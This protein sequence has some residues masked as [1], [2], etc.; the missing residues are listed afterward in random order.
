MGNHVKEMGLSAALEGID[1]LGVARFDAKSMVA[2]REKQKLEQMKAEAYD[3]AK[4]NSW[5]YTNILKDCIRDVPVKS[6]RS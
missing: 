2:W 5:S 3:R 6:G 1:T 4:V